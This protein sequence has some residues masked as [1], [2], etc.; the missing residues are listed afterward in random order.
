MPLSVQNIHSYEC[1]WTFDD[2]VTAPLHG[3]PHVHAYYRA[4]SSRQ[5][6]SA[7]R[8]PTLIIHAKDD[9]FMTPEAIPH[10]DELSDQVTLE[11]S[12]GG[13]HVGFIAGHV[14]GRPIYWLDGRMVRHLVEFLTS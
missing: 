5:Y 10:A 2:Q 4:A 1:F 8:T 12:A 9:P 13:G 7:I 6:L 14:P 11:V 3:F